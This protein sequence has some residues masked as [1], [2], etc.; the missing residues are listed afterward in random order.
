MAVGVALVVSVAFDDARRAA[1]LIGGC[2]V[3]G[4]LA[5]GLGWIVLTAAVDSPLDAA[6]ET[7][8]DAWQLPSGLRAVLADVATEL[9]EQL[10][11]VATRTSLV[12]VA[13]GLVL[14]AGSVVLG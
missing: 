14:V 9:S 6:T 1:L 2:W 7:G 8:P 3:A 10:G 5:V 11:G 4:G 13:A 12:L